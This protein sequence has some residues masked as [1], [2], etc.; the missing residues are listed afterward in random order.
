[1]AS[2]H[3]LDKSGFERAWSK[4]WS[5]LSP[6][7]KGLQEQI[8][9]IESPTIDSAL[10]TT[11]TNAVENKVVSAALNSKLDASETEITKAFHSVFP[12]V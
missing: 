12:D 3:V 1:M 7:F 2:E 10:S 4:L 8:N 11:S 5:L 6:L 9:A